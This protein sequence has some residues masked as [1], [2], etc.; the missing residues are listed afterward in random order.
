MKRLL[1]VFLVVALAASFV[2]AAPPTIGE[3]LH[4]VPEG[5]QAVIAVDSAAL[6]S[7][8]KVQEWLL[9]QHAWTGADEDLRQFLTDAGLDPVRDVDAMVVTVLRK[10]G[11][12]GA[13]ALFSGRYDPASLAAA[14]V[15]RGAQPFTLGA[16]Q[17]YRLPSSGHHSGEAAVLV[18]PSPELVIVGEESAVQAAVAPPHAVAPLI[19]TEISAGHID[20]RA[21]FWVVAVVPAEARQKARE[22][23]GHVHG[24]GSET[25]RSVVVASG[26]VQRVAGQAFLDDS[27]RFSG[28]AI[29]DTPENAELLRDAVKGAIAAARLHA[30]GQAPELVSVLRDVEV[31]VA[32]TD[33]SVSGAVPLTL[34]EKLAAEHTSPCE[35]GVKQQP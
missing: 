34:L 7:H 10:G 30:Q 5:A 4:S 32:G 1:P 35:S 22:A 14:L 23:S 28:V 21:P 6:R 2:A 20:L 18:Q 29:A 8:P 11:E 9:R 24:E 15:K 12:T 17:A 27:L 3:L 13:V 31:R 26:T 33:V 16:R 25:V 19:E